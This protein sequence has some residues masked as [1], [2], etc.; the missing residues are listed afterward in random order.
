MI[1]EKELLA[2]LNR[3][4]SRGREFGGLRKG[5]MF[6]TGSL[7]GSLDEIEARR[8]SRS[9]SHSKEACA[10]TKVNRRNVSAQS[11]STK[12]LRGNYR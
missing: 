7:E 2:E 10:K 1:S 9:H 11:I 6:E 12:L 3:L 4:T 8:K 5:Y